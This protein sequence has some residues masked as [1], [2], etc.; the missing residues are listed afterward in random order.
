MH[1]MRPMMTA[2]PR[3]I[4][5]MSRSS[6]S[7]NPWSRYRPITAA[8]TETYVS[9]RAGPCL[10]RC[11]V[12]RVEQNEPACYV[13]RVSNPTLTERC[14]KVPRLD[15]VA[16]FELADLRVEPVEAAVRCGFR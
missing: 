9:G 6:S 10:S 3:P 14:A 2:T 12:A 8:W 4:P 1:R 16:N 5:D 7:T 11:T 15:L 13:A